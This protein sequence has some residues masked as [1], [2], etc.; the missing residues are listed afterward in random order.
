[1]PISLKVNGKEIFRKVCPECNEAFLPIDSREQFCS[2]ACEKRH[3]GRKM[4]FRE[5]IKKISFEEREWF[6]EQSRKK[7]NNNPLV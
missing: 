2:E 7:K 1:M 6:K 5:H 4:K 3:E